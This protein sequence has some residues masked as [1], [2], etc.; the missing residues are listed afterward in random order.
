MVGSV[1]WLGFDLG[2]MASE[3]QLELEKSTICECCESAVCLLCCGL[4]ASWSRSCV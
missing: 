1:R 3:F 4:G 2:T